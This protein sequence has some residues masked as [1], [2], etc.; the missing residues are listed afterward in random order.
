MQGRAVM[1]GGR[2]ATLSGKAFEAKVKVEVEVEVGV[3]V[4]EASR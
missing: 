4:W 2:D 1:C 3:L